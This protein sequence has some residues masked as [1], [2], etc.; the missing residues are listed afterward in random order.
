[1][2]NQSRL[3]AAGIIEPNT[4]LTPEQCAA[5]EKLS[6]QQVDQLI[7]VRDSLKAGTGVKD[8]GVKDSLGIAPGINLPK[9]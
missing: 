5:I 9:P 6:S 3:E 4:V 1:M 7:S 2:S 8:S